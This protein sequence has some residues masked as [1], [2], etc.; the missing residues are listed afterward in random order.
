MRRSRIV[1]LLGIVTLLVTAGPVPCHS[2]TVDAPEPP[3]S[4]ARI[5]RA[6][7]AASI[8]V[9]VQEHASGAATALGLDPAEAEIDTSSPHRAL[10]AGVIVDPHGF[11]LASARAVS[12]A[13][14]LEV[15]LLDGT[16]LKA[17]VVGIDWRTDVAVMRLHS[18][19]L[20]P[21]LAF[22]DSDRARAGDWIVAV[23]TPWG[24]EG[25]VT[26][27]VIT[28]VPTPEGSNPLGSLLQ[29]DAALGDRFAGGPLVAMNGELV[30]LAT[31][32]GGEGIGYAL[33]AA[34]VRKV[35]VELLEKGRVS[36]PWLGAITQQLSAELARA[37]GART[38]EGVL[39][40]DVL[41]RSPAAGAGLRSGDV[42]VE[43]NGRAVSSRSQLERTVSLL[44]PGDTVRLKVRRAARD[45]V[46]SV[47]LGEEPVEWEAHPD[48]VRARRL[49]G[50]DV[51]PVTPATGAVVIEVDGDSPADLVGVEPGDVI[52]EIDRKPVHNIAEFQAIAR[53]IRAGDDVLVLVQ[54][55]DIAVYVILPARPDP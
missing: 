21:Y 36:R 11:A 22:A 7:L 49:L 31:R 23:G 41:P 42:L 9:R 19:A 45:L 43:I 13:P 20:L 30:G 16:Q 5:A 33:P 28:A 50:I 48:L 38:A 51:R 54:R 39:V 32:L 52:R 35:Y 46:L 17:D 10:G 15:A 26:A 40:A 47:G 18:K 6:A 53:R 12:R 34:T 4:F 24:L 25:T 1:V 3:A 27:G 37:F 55:A 14:R 2:G 8:V 44:S 29:T